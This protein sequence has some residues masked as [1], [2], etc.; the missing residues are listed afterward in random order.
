MEKVCTTE[1]KERLAED[2]VSAV[3][4]VVPMLANV[5][6]LEM[7]LRWGSRLPLHQTAR[8]A[9]WGWSCTYKGSTF[10]VDERG[11][12]SEQNRAVFV[13]CVR[14][15]GL[16]CALWHRSLG[17]EGWAEPGCACCRISTPL[18]GEPMHVVCH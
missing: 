16:S 9:L 6:Y 10:P 7:L 17:G 5:M 2:Y 4:H 18:F 11:T 15:A 14:L 8:G 1:V 3:W 13:A 12:A